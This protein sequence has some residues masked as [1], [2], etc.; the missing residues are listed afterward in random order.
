MEVLNW[1]VPTLVLVVGAWIWLRWYL[2]YGREHVPADPPAR[3]DEPPYDW[4]PVQLGQ[5]WSPGGL[6][7]KDMV[8]SLI[9]L[10]RRGVLELRSEA[11]S[12]LEAGG[13]AGVSREY[14]YSVE[15]S[16]GREGDVT[17]S[18]R[19]LMEE[20]IF[21]HAGGKKRASLTEVMVEGARERGA[22]CGRIERW[23]EIA[24][25]EPT[26]FPFV[27]AMSKRMSARGS[28]L[29]AAMLGGSFVLG[30]VFPSLMVLVLVIVAALML[31]GSGV[32]SRRSPEGAEALA[33]WQAFRR[34]LVEVSSVSDAPPHSAVVWEKYLVYGVSLGVARRVIGAFRL[35]H[36]TPGNIS[37]STDLY[38][39][40]FALGGD[41]FC[42][43]FVSLA[44]KDGTGGGP[45]GH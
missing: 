44:A 37:A 31:V 39:P 21:R 17:P 9:D 12:V 40:V 10:V 41:P 13:M 32:I 5:L 30:M 33:R 24:E 27:D 36:P 35:L 18:E 2:R 6:G 28:T 14:D 25:E 22:T 15:L 19:Y 11:V 4:S 45:V 38:R 29:G 1:L 16:A 8:A 42:R 34:H 7:L 3:L 23:R 43:A 26:P 20:I